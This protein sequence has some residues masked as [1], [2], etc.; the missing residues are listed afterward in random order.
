MSSMTKDIIPSGER[1]QFLVTSA[2]L[3]ELSGG[4][5][6]EFDALL[7]AEAERR[8]LLVYTEYDHASSGIVV[9]WIPDPFAE[10]DGSETPRESA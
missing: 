10:P 1:G 2:K 6:R 4:V 8:R 3:V 9:R 7:Q 5:L